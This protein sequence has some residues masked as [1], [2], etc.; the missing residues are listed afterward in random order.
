MNS[1]NLSLN[2]FYNILNKKPFLLVLS[3]LLHIY[4]VFL[5]LNFN[6]SHLSFQYTFNI[7]LFDLY[8]NFGIDGISFF[9]YIF[10]VFYFTFMFNTYIL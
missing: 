10:S 4:V 3:W 2:Y 6:P 7:K 8:L 1:I 5:W 9:F